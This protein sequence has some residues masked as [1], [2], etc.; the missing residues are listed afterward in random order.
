MTQIESVP[1]PSPPQR[2]SLLRRWR[3]D[4]NPVW[5]REMRQ[6]AR[7]QRTPIILA[8]VTAITALIICAVGGVASTSAPPADVGVALFH[9]FFSLAFAVVSWIGPGVAAVTIA[10]ERSGGTWEAMLLTGLGARRIARGKFLASLTYIALYL[11]MLAPVGA[12]PFLFG[13]ITATEVFAAFLLLVLF[14]ALAVGFG[15]SVSSALVSPGLAAVVTLPIAVFLSITAYLLLGVGLSV[16]AHQLWPGVVEGAPVWLP[17]AYVRADF[18]VHYLVYLVAIPLGSV[19]LLAWF[20]FETTISNMAAPSD[21]RVSG[22]KRWLLVATPSFTA[23]TVA[24]AALVLS[25]YWIAVLAGITL[26]LLFAVLVLFLFASDSLEPS[27]RV[28]AHWDRSGA[29]RFHRAIGPG[30]AK[31]IQLV[32]ALQ[33]GALAIVAAAGVA[34]ETHH[35]SS[36]TDPHVQSIIVLACYTAAF[37]IFLGGLV[38]WVRAQ[39]TGGTVPRLLLVLALFVAVVGPWLA[40]AIAGVFEARL[41]EILFIAA[42]SPAYAFAMIDV[43]DRTSP[44][45]TMIL[46]A[47]KIC[48]AVWALAGVILY[49][50]GARRIHRIIAERTLARAEF[51][52]RLDDDGPSGGMETYRPPAEG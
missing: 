49:L 24:A 15:L 39:S 19:A 6:S 18:G 47:G 22:L 7:M 43:L 27:A 13:G 45:S 26:E 2:P 34:I 35:G 37:L 20:F 11:V 10:S 8:S 28:R 14:A 38:T 40:L 12:L 16:V 3:E 31:T 1:F 52:A 9:T 48:M 51:E 30:I 5:L 21:D 4:P 23:M 33:L 50:F 17:T 44:N 32:L 41:D 42:P 29:G 36:R 25:D 46:T